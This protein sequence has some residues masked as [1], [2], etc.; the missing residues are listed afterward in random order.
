[1][2]S[3]KARKNG[4]VISSSSDPLPKKFF[5]TVLIPRNLSWKHAQPGNVTYRWGAQIQVQTLQEKVCQGTTANLKHVAISLTSFG[6]EEFNSSRLHPSLESV[7][8]SLNFLGENKTLKTR[9]RT[10]TRTKTTPR[11]VSHHGVRTAF[12]SANSRFSNV[13]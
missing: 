10:R 1:M 3:W 4:L 6:S 12:A 2:L 8:P 11:L 13:R 7:T 5:Y 9:S